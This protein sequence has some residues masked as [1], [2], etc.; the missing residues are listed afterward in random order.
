[1]APLELVMRSVDTG[2]ETVERNAPRAFVEGM[3]GA[4]TLAGPFAR[5]EAG[6]KLLPRLSAFAFGEWRPVE[7][8]TGA[9]LR[10]S[11]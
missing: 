1:M 11:F 4:S 5:V 9:G 3:V 10:W 7:S 8:S 2:L 6:A